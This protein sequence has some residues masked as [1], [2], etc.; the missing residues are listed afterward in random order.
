MKKSLGIYVHIPFCIKK[1]LYC[2]FCSFPEMTEEKMT[3]YTKA[4][5]RDLEAFAEK[6]SSEYYV[7]TVY[8]G[9][10]T[11]TLLPTEC[12]SEI[13]DALYGSFDIIPD[14]EIT[15][16]CNP[17]T[18]DLKKLTELRRLGINRLSIGLQS[19][20]DRE[21]RALGRLHSFEDFKRIFNE[22][23]EA[24]FDNISADLMY[25]IPLQTAESF[26]ETLRTVCL[27]EP[28][29]ISAYCL[30][31]E[32]GTPF[33]SKRDS[34]VLPDEDCELEMYLSCTEILGLNGYEKYE[35]SNFS[36]RGRESRHNLRYWRGD[37]Y[38]GFGVGA[39]SYVDGVR[40]GNSRDF[41]GFVRGEDITE[42]R[43]Q[44]DER[45]RLDEYIMLSLRLREGLSC[46][47]L[48]RRTGLDLFEFYPYAEILVKNGIMRLEG[49]RLSFTDRGFFVSNSV[50]SD[51]ISD[52]D[53]NM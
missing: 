22:A 35:I 8:F 40:F 43:R 36:K 4:I 32:E 5:T 23:R 46:S 28:E 3:A 21:L 45:E 19:V 52:R 11:P 39:Y 41:G 42:E 49:D 6:Y 44:I 50:L 16:E 18:A 29:H 12:F 20:H 27:L 24:G 26:R 14:A 15:A 51:M 33:Y 25:G 10:G 7:D 30:K 47:E 48:K 13:F 1:C 37:D 9:G 38:I 53:D 17:A 31:I 2:D 34:L